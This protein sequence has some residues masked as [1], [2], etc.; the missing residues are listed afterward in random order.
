MK[1]LFSL[2][3]LF[4]AAFVTLPTLATASD[5]ESGLEKIGVSAY[6]ST[7][8]ATWNRKLTT[9]GFNSAQS[10]KKSTGEASEPAEDKSEV[11]LGTCSGYSC[12]PPR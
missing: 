1:S 5:V 4:G 8:H 3:F 10:W 2:S 6:G 9:G 7:D 11:A 12:P